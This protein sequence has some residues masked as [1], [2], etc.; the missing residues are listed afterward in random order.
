M[1]TVTYHFPGGLYPSQYNP[2]LSG[3][4]VNPTF[5]ELVDMSESARST[6]TST[7]VLYRLDNGLKLKLVGTGFSFDSSG[8]AVGG[9]ITSIQVLLNNGTTLVQTISGLNLSLE[10]F[11]DAAAAFDNAK[12]ENWLMSGGDTINGSAGD[13]D[14][15]GRGGNDILNGNDGDDT[16]TG[17]EGDDTYDGGA[18]FDTLSFQDAY[19][20][21]TAFRG[22]NLNAATGTVIDQFGFSETFQN[23]EQYGGTQFADAMVGSSADDIFMGLGGRDTING[24]AGVDTVRYDRD[25]AQ[26]A[27]KG[28]SVNLTTGVAIDSFGSQDTL[29]SIENVRATN[30]KDTIVGN[31]DSNFLRAFA[32]ADT[33]DGKA[34]ADRMRGG[35]GDDTYYVD[36]AGD[37]VDESLDNGAG[38]DMVRSSVSFDLANSTAVKGSVERLALQGSGAINGSG[39]ALSNGLTGNGAANTLNGAAGNDFINGGLGNDTLIGSTGLDTFIFSSALNAASNVDTISDF[40]VADDVM[41]IDNAVFAGVVGTGALTAAQFAS[42]TTGLAADTDDRIIY[43]SDTG[44][45]FYDSDGNGAGGSVHFATVSINL[46]ITA[47]DFIIT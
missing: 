19:N 28:V 36:N 10:I 20:A 37:I 34:G 31:S 9:T 1:A 15:S 27:S 45:L 42:N 41:W 3:V 13:D 22:I 26:G 43:E 11:Q 47:G 33:L 40:V 16:I 35:A 5:G 12:F 14:I 8:D 4:S 2:P 24:G 7:E 18:G 21:P 17:G 32:G 25:V 23:F 38:I 39:N 46:G 44:K 29:S 30:F 6:T